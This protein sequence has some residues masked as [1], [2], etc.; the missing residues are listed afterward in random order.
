M[1]LTITLSAN[2]VA[3]IGSVLVIAL[4]CW[5]LRSRIE[6]DPEPFILGL[7]F[8]AFAGQF[9]RTAEWTSEIIVK[10]R[11]PGYGTIVILL[12]LGLFT[13]IGQAFVMK[14]HMLITTDHYAALLRKHHLKPGQDH[15]IDR[16]TTVLLRVTDT[17][18]FP[19]GYRLLKEFLPIKTEPRERSRKLAVS[20]LPTKEFRISAEAISAEALIVPASRRRKFYWWLYVVL[21][22]LSWT[23]FIWV[24]MIPREQL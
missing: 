24:M 9:I 21:C 22:I 3:F 12:L 20:V 10:G 1:I 6:S 18:F 14:T 2:S 13:F 19:G 15:Q 11:V 17:D 16:W 5:Y 23:W 8:F 4:F 7:T